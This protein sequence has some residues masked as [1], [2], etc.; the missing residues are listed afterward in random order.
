MMFMQKRIQALEE[1]A[2]GTNFS[3]NIKPMFLNFK[4]LDKNAPPE[5]SLNFVE[6]ITFEKLSVHENK[7]KR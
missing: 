3:E 2:Q 5:M 1:K 4:F 6:N 7:R